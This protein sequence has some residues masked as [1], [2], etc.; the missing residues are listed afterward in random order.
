MPTPPPEVLPARAYPSKPTVDCGGCTFD[1]VG[2]R[3]TITRPAAGSLLDKGLRRNRGRAFDAEEV[4]H[5]KHHDRRHTDQH[6]PL[7]RRH[8]AVHGFLLRAGRHWHGCE[9][10]RVR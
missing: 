8:A 10:G 9:T 2:N 1:L 6:D 3:L 4:D 7:D 5:A